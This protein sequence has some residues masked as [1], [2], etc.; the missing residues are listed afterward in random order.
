MAEDDKNIDFSFDN[1]P[2]KLT[3]QDDVDF[4]FADIPVLGLDKEKQDSFSFDQLPE[5]EDA[6]IAS[7]ENMLK[8]SP[9]FNE[10]DEYDEQTR[11]T[12]EVKRVKQGR[13]AKKKKQLI[14]KM[15]VLAGV[16]V[17]LCIIG[18]GV[19]F[20]LA[21]AKAKAAAE[22][23]KLTPAQRAA[24]RVKRQREK[25]RK[26]VEKAD[27]VYESGET[28][29]AAGK[30]A[31]ILK[32]DAN[33]AAAL[34]GS[35]KC[36]ESI[37]KV[38]EAE[39]YYTEAVQKKNA[40][41]RPFAAL[42]AIMIGKKKFKEAVEL[43]EQAIEKFPDEKTIL[44]PLADTYHLLDDEIKALETYRKIPKA[45]L[46][47]A[48][49]KTYAGL[50]KMDSKKDAKKLYIYTAGK[51]KDLDSYMLASNLA[52][53]I[54]DKVNI[55]TDAVSA[56]K[57]AENSEDDAKFL[58]ARA[59]IENDDKDKAVAV[60]K[61]IQIEKLSLE[62]CKEILALAKD[63]GIV[64]L[65]T[66]CTS[67]LK[68]RPDDLKL[69]LTVQKQLTLSE[70][71]ET[72]MEV[73][74]N[75]WTANPNKAIANFL[76]AKTLRHSTSAIEYYRKAIALDPKFFHAS[77]ELGKIYMD[78]KNWLEAEKAFAH[79]A[80]TLRQD[81]NA[82]F[83]FALVSVKNGKGQTAITEYEKFLDSQ[84]LSR[85]RKAVEL[86]PLAMLLPT[87]DLAD[88]Y[89][90]RIQEDSK[91]IKEYKLNRAKRYLLYNG[92][93][94]N[95][96][97]GRKTGKFREYCILKMLAVG[98]EREVLMMSTPKEDF[99]DFWKVFIARKM[100]FKNWKKSAE[101]LYKKNKNASDPTTKIIAGLWLG[102]ISVVAFEK[103][104]NRIPFDK[105][106]LF[107]MMLAEEY[108]RNKQ[109]TK[110]VIR[111]LKA[112]NASRN[113]YSGVVEH[114]SKQR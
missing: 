49:L 12:M 39:K 75:W 4:T 92:K 30:Y 110:A 107:Y 7:F 36:C 83:L 43:L 104:I 53:D 90:S 94:G 82:R 1:D 78:A 113:V 64:D 37:E 9:D 47:K 81:K 67:L 26:M 87:P 35:G 86:I 111:Y 112:K 51:F 96:F 54:E 56:M 60:I 95:A 65:K 98:K 2:G 25:I 28:S 91:F 48:S 42:A 74:S 31:K 8:D 50:I 34:T 84:G 88:K 24:L 29:K 21:Q 89:L 114:Y 5:G 101:M 70:G 3:N 40:D 44:I 6:S 109:A 106:A 38:D 27:A 105:E 33:N 59:L 22:A 108:K 20:S 14:I 80:K 61:E 62:F 46:K 23:K 19:M 55:L 16:V 72:A 18:A 68:A 100:N 93:Q 41:E 76:Y 77:M 63:A 58:F 85:S 73:Y 102:K 66:F 97:S 45:A 11:T 10:E 57:D 13:G 32:I 99:P 103:M 52:D 69:Q 71:T 15:A 17:L 79:C